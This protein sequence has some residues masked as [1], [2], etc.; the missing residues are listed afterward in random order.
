MSMAVRG[1]GFS[2]LVQN[3]ATPKLVGFSFTSETYRNRVM[4]STAPSGSVIYRRFGE[5]IS[6]ILDMRTRK[7]T[8][9]VIFSRV[10]C[11]GT[12]GEI[13]GSTPERTLQIAVQL[14]NT[15]DAAVWLGGKELFSGNLGVGSAGCFDLES[16]PKAYLTNSFD[17]AEFHIPR[18]VFADIAER[19]E[20]GQLADLSLAC[21]TYDPILE[22]LART[23][24]ATLEHPYR[25]N[26][27]FDDALVLTLY[28]HL[29]VVYGNLKP[30]RRYGSGK[31]APWQE[32]RAKELIDTHLTGG[33]TIDILAAA[34]ALSP[35]HF[36]RAFKETTG[37]PPHRW[38]TIRRVEMAK[39][40][41]RP[42]MLTMAEVAAASGFADQSH[43]SRVFGSIVGELPRLWQRRQTL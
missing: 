36:K 42:G 1:H 25:A 28:W 41:M 9:S 3:S 11:E 8:S 27:L 30:E 2:T 7:T 16:E 22:N 39:S 17:S 37:M 34:C 14:R 40:L 43:F 10:Q 6:P 35:S 32:R 21:G 19:H 13:P 24:T 33:I 5:K 26:A 12:L 20:C 23:M 18:S 29:A 4:S 31:L 38:L 15:A